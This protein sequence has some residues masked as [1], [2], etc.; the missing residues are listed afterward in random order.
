MTFAINKVGVIG[1]GQMGSGI[2]HVCAQAGLDVVMNDVAEERLKAGLATING[3]LARQVAKGQ[4][5]EAARQAT[6]SR[7]STVLTQDKLGDCDLII[8]AAS[9]NEE[10]KRKIFIGLRPTRDVESQGLDINEHG[11]EGYIL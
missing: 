5:D 9:E 4:I 10:I 11:E 8:E 6:L 3:L 1:A 7:I 2:A